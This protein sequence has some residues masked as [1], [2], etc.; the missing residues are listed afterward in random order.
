VQQRALAASRRGLL[1]RAPVVVLIALTYVAVLHHTYAQH[2]APFFAY[3]QY[4][5]RPPDA[6]AYAFAISLVIALALV[7]PRRI[8]QPSH[9]IAWVLFIVAVVPAIIIPQI[10]PTLSRADALELAV[11]VA[12]SYLPVAALGTRR[13]LRGFVPRHPLRAPTFWP[14][15]LAAYAGLS[16]YVLA[17]AGLNLEL[18]SLDDVY[19]V[20]AELAATEE[21]DALLSYVVPLLAGVV[22]PVMLA[23]GLWARKWAWVLAG[24]LGQVF[25]YSVSGNKTAVLSPI[26]LAGVYL[27]LRSRRPPAATACLLAAPVVAVAMV[28]I[29]H[30][31]RSVPGDLTSL[32][33]RRFLVTPGLL[34]AGYVQ[35][36]DDIDKAHLAHSIL[37]PFFDYPYA[38]EP[39]W[40]VGA[41]FF[42]NPETHANANLLADGFANF[43]HLGMVAACLVAVVLLWAVDDAAEGLPLGFACLSVLMPALALVDSGILTTMLTHGFLATVVLL[44]LAPRTGWPGRASPEQ[45]P[46]SPEAVSPRSVP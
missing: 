1:C 5:Y 16:G 30:L 26:A 10:T 9:F 41:A 11:W 14:L 40:L 32:I 46:A 29:D 39:P 19:G 12:I 34:T 17:T 45:S 24:V 8:S 7:L 4:A 36:F 42:D 6:L 15:L 27:L 3:L 21:D 28:L 25:V 2:V 13:A 18:P 22:N 31:S 43:G 20:R 38:K 33:V 23:R 35:V 37:S 44:A